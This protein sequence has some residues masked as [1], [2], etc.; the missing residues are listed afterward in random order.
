MSKGKE[1]KSDGQ[2]TNDKARPQLEAPLTRIPTNKKPGNLKKGP[3]THPQSVLLDGAIS[4]LKKLLEILKLLLEVL[5][6]AELVLRHSVI[7]FVGSFAWYMFGMGGCDWLNRLTGVPVPSLPAR[8]PTVSEWVLVTIGLLAPPLLVLHR[9]WIRRRLRKRL[10]Y[11]ERRLRTCFTLFK[12]LKEVDPT[13][14]A[15][16]TEIARATKSAADVLEECEA[17]LREVQ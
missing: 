11:A 14:Q 15:L 7:V 2:K 12:F 17:K 3:A 16:F 8:V 10:L 13:A 9:A 6:S 5:L 4:R 1:I